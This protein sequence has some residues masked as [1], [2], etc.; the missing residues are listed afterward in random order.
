MCLGNAL[1]SKIVKLNSLQGLKTKLGPISVL[2][3]SSFF[4]IYRSKIELLA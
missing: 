1:S 4:N 2:P 3:D